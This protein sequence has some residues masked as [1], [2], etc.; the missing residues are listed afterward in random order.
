MCHTEAKDRV[1]DP[2]A[3]KQNSCGVFNDRRPTKICKKFPK[4]R[5]TETEHGNEQRTNK[6][7]RTGYRHKE[8][9][10]ENRETPSPMPSPYMAVKLFRAMSK[11]SWDQ[12]RRLY[13]VAFAGMFADQQPEPE[14][15]RDR[16][17]TLLM[18]LE[19]RRHGRRF[20]QWL[21]Y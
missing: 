4:W 9:N 5:K 17:L 2:P 7:N 8:D 20:I 14:P 12:V 1:E 16:T 21:K 11:A 18:H 13:L 6:E 15:Y 19:D 10:M 3:L